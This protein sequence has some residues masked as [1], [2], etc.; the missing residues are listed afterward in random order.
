MMSKYHETEFNIDLYTAYTVVIALIGGNVGNLTFHAHTCDHVIL[1][2]SLLRD[3]VQMYLFLDMPM[4]YSISYK[5]II[6]DC[7][8]Q[9]SMQHN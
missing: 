1:F 9:R 8:P 7:T 6:H 5:V 4:Y 2:Q 3:V